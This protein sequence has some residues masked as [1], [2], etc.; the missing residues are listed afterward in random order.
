MSK[1]EELHRIL[2]SE[3]RNKMKKLN[4]KVE[5]DEQAEIANKLIA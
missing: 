5:Q 2:Y 3:L 1:Q 4:T